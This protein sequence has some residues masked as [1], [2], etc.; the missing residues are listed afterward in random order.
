[1]KN[2]RKFKDFKYNRICM[3]TSM[4]SA[5]K[6]LYYQMNFQSLLINLLRILGTKSSQMTLKY[7][8]AS[9]LTLVEGERYF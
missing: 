1:M 6:H 3:G 8:Y 2:A 7:G 9:L 5:Q 4:P